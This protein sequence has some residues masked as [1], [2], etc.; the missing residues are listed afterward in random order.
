MRV[1]HLSTFWPNHGHT[2]YTDNLIRGMRTH[3]P[4]RHFVLAERGATPA[5]TDAFTCIPCFHRKQDYVA[6]IV[7][8]AR[9][10]QPD[11][12]VIQYS[13]DLFG[14]DTRF[15]RLLM[16][17]RQA[18]IRTI[19]N[20]HSVYP[21]RQIVGFRPGRTAAD[22]D[23]AMGAEATRIQVHTARM[24]DDLIARR[25][26][27]DKIVVIPHGSKAMEQ[28]DP[29]ASRAEL[30]LPADAKIVVFFGFIWLGKGVDFLLSVFKQVQRQVPEAF[31]LVAGH[32]RH[33]IWSFYVKYLKARAAMLGIGPRSLFWG[34]YVGEQMV[35]TIFSAAD[36]VA[37]PYRQDYSSV[38]G[39][40]H[41][42]AGIGKLMLCSRISKFDE[43]EAFAP[44]LTAP[45][46]D[47]AAWTTAMVRLLRDAELGA[48]AREKI[49]RFGDETSWPRLGKVH[50]DLYH[51]LLGDDAKKAASC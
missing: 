44:E 51:Q 21:E 28:R 26:S 7:T 31:L 50:L 13:N 24:R 19:V 33:N 20:T 5:E 40:V 41:Q 10:I 18:G 49:I 12:M 35:P 47:R 39:V 3:E 17:L 32:T 43:I 4:E 1:S 29:A 38:S 14:D 2:H 22:F 15:P 45:Y 36:V 46:G 48:S 30:G 9:K 37:L 8:E 23:R 6:G 25:V 42:A 11:I 16:E 34:G 27:A